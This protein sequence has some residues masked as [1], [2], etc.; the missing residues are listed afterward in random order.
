MKFIEFKLALG[1]SLA[2]FLCGSAATALPGRDYTLSPEMNEKLEKTIFLDLRDIN[3]VDV[4]KFIAVQGGLNVVTSKN[5]QGRATLVL[6]NVKIRDA[7]DILVVS[8]QLAYEARENIIFIMSEDEYVQSRG[9]TFNDKRKVLTRT[10]QFAKPTYVVTALQAVQSAL[11]KIVV[12]EDTGTVVMIDTAEKLTQMNALLD[13]LEYKLETK[14]IPLQYANA[15]DIEA[16]LK[17]SID[18]KGVGSIQADERSNQVV[19]TAYPGR[20]DSILPTVTAL[21]KQT[22]AVLVEARILQITLNPKYDFGIDWEKL[23]KNH[24]GLDFQGSFPID[25]GAGGALTHFGK[26]AVGNVQDGDLSADIRFLK[27]VSNTK[28]LAN[29][30]VMILNKQESKIN[31][32]DRIPYV[33]TTSTGTGANVS[34]SEDIRFI[35]VGINLVVTPIINDDGYITMKI[36]PEISSQTGTLT[37]PTQNQI[38][39]VNTTYIETSVIVKDGVTIVLGGLR[40]DD[41]TE[42]DRGVPYL[43]DIPWVGNAFRSRNDSV[44][45]KEILVFITPKIVTG[46]QDVY[47]RALDIKTGP[48][49]AGRSTVISQQETVAVADAQT[50]TLQAGAMA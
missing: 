17:A 36:R 24:N 25:T 46:G 39:L 27:Q 41:V 3:V 22:K 16:Q 47:D 37:T 13:Q 12:D 6:K 35:D 10:L 7:L 9:K 48:Y 33:V 38:P 14:V 31:I 29:P 34:V 44:A 2:M 30:R 23:F 21:D 4:F 8:N 49:P 19:L 43:M 20:M 5:V 32:G 42:E 50:S 40:R 15:K 11:G 45:R 26:I 18:A 28:I 1:F